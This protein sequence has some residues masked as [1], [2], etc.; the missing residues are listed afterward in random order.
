MV[1]A[2]EALHLTLPRSGDTAAA[3]IGPIAADVLAVQNPFPDFDKADQFR[4]VGVPASEPAPGLLAV[5]AARGRLLIALVVAVE[6]SLADSGKLHA[7]KLVGALAAQ[8]GGK[9]GGR[10]DI[11]QAGGSDPSK[12]DDALKSLLDQIP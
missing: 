3:R 9:G 4:K 10:P 1:L 12:L 5:G 8:V 11:A 6:K 7:G 2:G